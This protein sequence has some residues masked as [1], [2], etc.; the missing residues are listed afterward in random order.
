MGIKSFDYFSE[1]DAVALIL[2]TMPG[3]ESLAKQEYYAHP[4]N[5][6]W[7][8]IARILAPELT[9]QEIEALS[10]D[11]KK[12]LLLTNRIAL[13]DVLEHCD[14]K[15]SRDIAIRNE[16]RNNLKMFFDDHVSVRTV[17]FNGQ[18]AQEYFLEGFSSIIDARKLELVVLPSSSP[19]RQLNCFRKLKEWRLI[20]EKI[21]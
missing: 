11:S 20:Q 5:I 8:M 13:W 21:K 12:K 15:G 7:D 17:F 6:F 16:A 2:G 1:A 18:K 4:D 3:D 10:Y 14:R 9:E 19:S